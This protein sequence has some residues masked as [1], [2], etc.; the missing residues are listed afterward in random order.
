MTDLPPEHRPT[1]VKPN[2]EPITKGKELVEKWA[3][4]FGFGHYSRRVRRMSKAKREHF[5]AL[6]Y[7]DHEEEF[8]DV[9][10]V[11]DGT[12]PVKQLEYVVIHEMTHGLVGYAQ[13]HV[14]AEEVICNR[15]AR[16]IT[17]SKGPNE[18]HYKGGDLTPKGAPPPRTAVLVDAL[19]EQER[20]VISRLFFGQASMGEVAAELG[21]SKRQV[22]RIRNRALSRMGGALVRQV[23]TE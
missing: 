15:L 9:E 13:Q 19:P 6:V 14:S 17:R 7:F 2:V 16:A 10:L 23:V 21:I 1:T 12:L 11:P 22:G 4:R 3:T 18:H 5:F 8:F 20:E